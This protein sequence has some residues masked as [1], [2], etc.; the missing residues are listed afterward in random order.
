MIQAKA[1]FEGRTGLAGRQSPRLKKTG[2]DTRAGR[3]VMMSSRLLAP[4]VGYLQQT[5]LARPNYC[6]VRG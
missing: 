5:A 3:G 2:R 6:G 4:L 1:A